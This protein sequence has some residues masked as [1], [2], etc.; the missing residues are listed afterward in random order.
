MERASG[1]ADSA[2]P[3]GNDDISLP[4]LRADFPQF[5]I[6]RETAGNRTRYIARSLRFGIRPHTVVTA[7]LAE[8]RTE[9]RHGTS[10]SPPK[11][12]GR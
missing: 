8:L 11:I 3:V 5:R 12:D 1:D 4:A 9:L 10:S 7:D 6:W 2:R